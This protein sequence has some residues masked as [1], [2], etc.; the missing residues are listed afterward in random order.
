[1]HIVHVSSE[2]FPFSKTGGLAD[3][4]YALPK[5]QRRL[6]ETVKIFTPL[7]KGISESFDLIDTGF[8]TVVNT[9]VGH[10][11]FSVYKYLLENVEI[12]FFKN[13]YFFY[14]KDL[15]AENGYDYRDN[16]LRFGCFSIAALHFID[17]FDM[18]VDIIHVH[19]WQTSF[20]P[21]F[22]KTEY[23]FIK[24]KIMLTIHNLA[25]QGI[26]DRSCLNVLQ[27]PNYLYDINYLEFYGTVNVLKG[28]I[29]FSDYVTTV[30]PTYAQEIMT[31]KYGCGLEGVI[32]ANKHKLKGVLN[33]IDYEV[34]NPESDNKIIKKY[35]INNLKDKRENKEAFA[36]NFFIESALPLFIFISRFTPQK[37]A[38]ILI[39]YLESKNIV[40]AAFAILGDG[41]KDITTRFKHIG[42]NNPNVFVYTGFNEALAHEMYAAGDFLLMPSRFEPCGLSQLIAMKYGTIPIVTRTGGLKDTVIDISEGG[43]G[44]CVDDVNIDMLNYA[45][46]R[47][48]NLYKYKRKMGAIMKKCMQLDFSWMKSANEYINIYRN[49]LER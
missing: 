10:F 45:V 18:P 3:V 21:I 15:Y 46:E 17:Y 30:S 32:C 6:G 9:T 5:A 31:E 25:F 16:Y 11:D 23:P 37:G 19:D 1:M 47:A 24:S 48:V 49:L 33:G 34:W 43:Y 35:G 22:L 44:F 38:D 42:L 14:R 26:F 36:K 20:V 7:Y 39:E 13:P 29:V 28:A 40:K 27:L 4:V 12:Y 8:S 41:P 2:V